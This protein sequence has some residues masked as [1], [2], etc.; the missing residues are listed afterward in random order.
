MTNEQRFKQ[1]LEW[2]LENIHKPFVDTSII[3]HHIIHELHLAHPE[4]AKREHPHK[5]VHG[6]STGVLPTVT[7]DVD[8]MGNKYPLRFHL[9]TPNA[10]HT[11]YDGR[12]AIWHQMMLDGLSY[13]EA[14]KLSKQLADE[15][16]AKVRAQVKNGEGTK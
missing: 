10:S 16:A 7:I 15:A 5:E 14:D 6:P 8:H 9:L 12:P 11:I 1:C 4:D 3:E 13:D 2:I